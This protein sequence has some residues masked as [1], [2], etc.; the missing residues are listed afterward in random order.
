[1]IHFLDN[2]VYNT[3]NKIINE[4][5]LHKIILDYYKN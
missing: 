5:I 3:T 1:M 2:D 4:N